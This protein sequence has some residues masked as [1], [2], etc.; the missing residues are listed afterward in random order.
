MLLG[1]LLLGAATV[2]L[3]LG[4]VYARQEALLFHPDVLAPD[5]RFALGGD[6]HEVTID[7]PGA[8]LS[9]L[10]LERPGARG[11]VFFLHGNAGSLQTWFVNVDFYRRLGYDLF[12]LDYRGYGKSTGRVESEAQLRADVRAAWDQVAAR[13]EGRR[14]IIYGRSLGTALA[15]RL[16]AEVNPDLTVL[17]SP[18]RSM[19]ALADRHY[20]FLPR[21]ILRYPLRTEDD[22]P[23]IASPVLLV[24]GDRDPLIDIAHSRDLL[25][26]SPRATLLEVPGAAHNDVQDFPVYLDGLR[27]ALDALPRP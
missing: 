6:V 7:V 15:A 18:Y 27:A 3:G 2:A 8:R 26:R 24:H 10:H 25:S 11:L 17:V 5:H 22:V 19:Q 9:A 21:S 16:A 13:Y 14:R 4:W 23:R 12:M 1:L 20:P